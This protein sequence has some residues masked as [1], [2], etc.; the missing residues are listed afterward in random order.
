MPR[1]VVVLFARPEGRKLIERHCQAAGVRMG[2]LQELVELEADQV[3]R[4]RKADL[5]PAF[6]VIL[7]GMDDEVEGV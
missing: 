5:W 6:D 1:N 2:D 7:D 3:G 4:D